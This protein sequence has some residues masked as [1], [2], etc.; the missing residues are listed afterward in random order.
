MAHPV[1]H[2]MASAK[3]YGGDWRE[4]LPIHDWFDESKSQF[5]DFRHRA[6]RHHSEGIFLCEKIF[7]ASLTLSTGRVVPVRWIGEDHVK[8]DCGFI[9]TA[10]D[11][12]KQI[13]PQSWMVRRQRKFKEL[14]E[15]M[16]ERPILQEEPCPT[17]V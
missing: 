12:L 14:E 15:A 16:A 2:A 7:G 17:P 6:L 1:H 3:R 11:W 13:K 5:A 10:A 8:E 9:P 4:F